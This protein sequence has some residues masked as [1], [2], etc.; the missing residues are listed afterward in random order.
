MREHRYEILCWVMTVLC[1]ALIFFLSGETG[2]QS[3]GR[4]NIAS[5]S[6]ASALTGETIKSADQTTALP[7]RKTLKSVMRLGA[8]VAEFAAF[9]FFLSLALFFRKYSAKK[10]SLIAGIIGV[11]YAASDESHQWFVPG[12]NADLPTVFYDSLGVAAGIAVAYGARALWHRYQKKHPAFCLVTPSRKRFRLRLLAWGATVAV[13]AMMFS[14]SA[15]NGTE[16]A[17]ISAMIAS[18]LAKTFVKGYDLMTNEAKE[19][20]ISSMQFWVRKGA[21][22]SEF[23][24]LGVTSSLAMQTYFVKPKWRFCLPAVLCAVAAFSDEIHQLFVAG[25]ACQVRDMAIDMAGGLCG[26]LAVTVIAFWVGRRR[27]EKK[28]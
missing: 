21:H 22:F 13:L 7:L 25:R 12:R 19:A 4:T 14:F 24:L 20:L 5:R 15:D 11:L 23:G 1:A 18:F 27:K 26:V 6:V 8:H 28:E 9:S 16:S 10:H 2:N 3:H 17:S